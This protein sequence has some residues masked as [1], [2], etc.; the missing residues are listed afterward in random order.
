MRWL[1]RWGAR[2]LLKGAEMFIE[3]LEESGLVRWTYDKKP[4]GD[5]KWEYAEIG[6]LIEAYEKEQEHE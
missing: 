4:Y 1:S 6:D 5:V 3:Y 2:Q